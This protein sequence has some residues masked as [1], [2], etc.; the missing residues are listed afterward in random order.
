[1]LEIMEVIDVSG[2]EATVYLQRHTACGD[3][4]KCM[5]A[6]QN[7]DMKATLKNTL[8]AK[9]GDRVSVEM[10]L[11]GLLGASFIMYGVPMAAFFIGLLLGFNVISPAIGMEANFCAFIT[12]LVLISAAYLFIRLLDRRGVFR[13]RYRL[14]MKGIIG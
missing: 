11:R 10:E 8:G 5:V 7:L 9:V 4:G 2:D 1:M 12:G 3:C 6:K 13:E 14:T